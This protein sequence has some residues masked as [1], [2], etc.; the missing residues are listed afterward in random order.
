M[1]QRQC[2]NIGNYILQKVSSPLS[3]G[4]LCSENKFNWP[5][6]CCCSHQQHVCQISTTS[7]HSHVNPSPE[8]SP[9]DE[10]KG[11]EPEEEVLKTK[12]KIWEQNIW[13]IPNFLTVSRI[14][15]TPYLG[16]LVVKQEFALAG[17]LFIFA[18]FTDM[19]DGHIART[20]PNQM[21]AFGSALDPLADKILISTLYITLSVVDLIPMPLTVLIF[22]RDVCLIG[23]AFYVRYLSLPPPLTLTRFFD[24]T[25]VTMQLKPTTISKVNTAIQ[26]GLVCATLA[27]PVFN[28]VDHTLLHALWYI[29]AGTTIWSG[30]GYVFRKDTYEIYKT[31]QEAKTKYK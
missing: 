29:T 15:L 3:N 24:G 23:A 31:T 6:N 4:S 12:K 8:K 17:G 27:A 5:M 2:R 1:I 13:T 19:L 11:D 26:F 9:Q 10:N 21:S 18:G 7:S 20:W 25:N 28:Y 22:A 16:Y 30:L 14:C